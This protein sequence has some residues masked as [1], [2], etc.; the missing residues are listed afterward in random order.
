MS[1]MAWLFL[2]IVCLTCSAKSEVV[3][4]KNGDRLS[5]NWRRVKGKDLLFKSED[6]GEVKIPLDRVAS[7]SAPEQVAVFTQS[8]QA[9]HGFLSLLPSGDWKVVKSGEVRMLPPESGAA[10]IPDKTIVRGCLRVR[11]CHGTVGKPR[12]TSGLACNRDFNRREL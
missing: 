6:L 10:V 8:G 3:I 1:R 5:G 7:F 11:P 9:F 12:Q 4:F 2:A